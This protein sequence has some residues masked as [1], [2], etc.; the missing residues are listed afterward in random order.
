[1]LWRTMP[2]ASFL[3]IPIQEVLGGKVGNKLWRQATRSL[4]NELTVHRD[5]WPILDANIYADGESQVSYYG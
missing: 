5:K 2:F 1:M 3:L 4:H